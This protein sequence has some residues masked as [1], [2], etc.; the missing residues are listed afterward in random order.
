MHSAWVMAQVPQEHLVP[1]GLQVLSLA[2]GERGQSAGGGETHAH[3]W[4]LPGGGR[5]PLQTTAH[6]QTSVP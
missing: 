2:G 3:S 5:T 4:V 1:S 6:V